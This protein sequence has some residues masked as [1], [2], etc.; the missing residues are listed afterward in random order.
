MVDL[1]GTGW[2]EWI[3][4]EGGDRILLDIGKWIIKMDIQHRSILCVF[5]IIVI[6][7]DEWMDTYSWMGFEILFIDKNIGDPDF[8]ICNY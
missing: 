7:L 4:R 1:V 6:L 2:I 3:S 8:I 5:I